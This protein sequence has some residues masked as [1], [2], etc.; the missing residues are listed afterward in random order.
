[1]M[2]II[3]RT[4]FHRG[5]T[6]WYIYVFLKP[7][8]MEFFL[9]VLTEFAQFSDKIFVITVKRFEPLSTSHLLGWRPACYHSASKTHVRDRIFK[10]SPIHGSMIISFA[11]FAEFSKSYDQFRKNSNSFINS[12]V[13][14]E[15][16]GSIPYLYHFHIRELNSV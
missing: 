15:L 4:T 13:Q 11:E 3:I 14:K 2:C 8:I 1:M 16:F 5:H 10:L 6:F 12:L 7:A 9:N